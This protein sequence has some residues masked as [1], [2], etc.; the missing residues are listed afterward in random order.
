M[1]KHKQ[2]EMEMEMQLPCPNFQLLP[3]LEVSYS[4]KTTR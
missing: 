2:M 4:S 1:Q 3:L